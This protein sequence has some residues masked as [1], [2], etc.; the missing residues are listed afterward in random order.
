M[1][2]KLRQDIR[3]QADPKKA[4]ILQGFFKTGKGDYAEG[5]RFLGLT[6]PISRS[7]AKRYPSL[8]L[9]DITTLLKSPIHEERFIALVLLV[10]RYKK[11]DQKTRKRIFDLYLKHT[12]YINNWDLVDTSAGY[13]V[14]PT[15]TR[16]QLDRLAT[17]T[18]LWERRIAMIACFDRIVRGDSRD[19]LRVARLLLHDPHDLIHKA[20]GWMLREVGKRCSEKTLR[21]FLD[22][23]A[24]EMPRT[25]LRYAI[26]KFS[27]QEQKHYLSFPSPQKS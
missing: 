13:I 18:L 8:P 6:V 19:A 9:A 23:H 14:G 2:R 15:V 26:E 27:K 1:L 20:V 5:D 12:R 3:K 24:H 21:A 11:G 7:I 25:M 4:K 10:D 17:S 16:A 22:E